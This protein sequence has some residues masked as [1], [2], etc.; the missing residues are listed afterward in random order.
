MV[1][2]EQCTDCSPKNVDMP[3]LAMVS[4]SCS[5]PAPPAEV[6]LKI[7]LPPWLPAL[8]VS[9]VTTFCQRYADRGCQQANLLRVG[10]GVLGREGG[11]W[12]DELRVDKA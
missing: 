10:P 4:Q 2:N 5:D 1:T 12:G 6:V 7:R 11:G 9:C 3:V 8:A